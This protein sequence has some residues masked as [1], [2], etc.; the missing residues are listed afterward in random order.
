M[1]VCKNLILALAIFSIVSRLWT[2]PTRPQ[3]LDRPEQL[4]R[5]E[6]GRSDTGVPSR[7]VRFA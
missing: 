1:Q 6:S 5:P 2:S 4:K 7:A 3:H